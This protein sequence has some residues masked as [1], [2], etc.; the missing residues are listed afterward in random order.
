MGLANVFINV[1]LPIFILIGLGLLLDRKL[2]IEAKAISQVI[3][4]IFSPALIF[5]SL[6]TSTVSGQDSAIIL[7]FMV[8]ITLVVGLLTWGLGRLARVDRV[9]MSAF[10]LTT[11]FMNSGNYG[12]SVNLFAFGEA[13]LARAAIYF[14]GSSI[15]TNTLG[16]FVAA[17]GRTNI[18]TALMRVFKAPMVYAVFA[19]FLVNALKI[20]VPE[21]VSKA[22]SLSAGGAVPSLLLLLGMQ[23][24]HVSLDKDIWLATASSL[25][26]LVVAAGLAWLLADLLGLEGVTRQVCIVESAMPA[27]VTPLIIAV[28]YNAKPKLVTSAIFV[29]TLASMLTL[30]IL[31]SLLM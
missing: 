21:P 1:L 18:K 5:S 31:L 25:I 17:K 26:R 23:L 7:A 9:T 20:T 10:L 12:L 16:I 8:I 13:G 15:L 28:E 3:F 2:H 22:L 27:A 11:L 29:S 19:A 4:Y 6:V 14:V 30:T 24:A